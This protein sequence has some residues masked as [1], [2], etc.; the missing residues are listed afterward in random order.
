MIFRK[1]AIF[2]RTVR[3]ARA[4]FGRSGLGAR[5]ARLLRMAPDAFR[6][7]GDHGANWLKPNKLLSIEKI[8]KYSVGRTIT[9]HLFCCPGFCSIRTALQRVGGAA[10]QVQQSEELSGGLLQ[11]LA[12][13]VDPLQ[14]GEGYALGRNSRPRPCAHN[15]WKFKIRIVRNDP[16]FG[17]I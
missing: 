11:L 7:L 5:R 10:L 17:K 4:Q 3:A 9:V 2:C 14:S 6:E 15:K 16:I 12:R 1:I 8:K 13:P